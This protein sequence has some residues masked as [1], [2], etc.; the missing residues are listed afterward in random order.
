MDS[1][2]SSNFHVLQKLTDSTDWA[3]ESL[4]NLLREC[5]TIVETD[6]DQWS[7]E[8]EEAGPPPGII[9][10]ICPNNCQGNGNCIEGLCQCFHPWI[11][12]DCS[13]N[14]TVPPELHKVGDGEPCDSVCSECLS[15]RLYGENFADV[16]NVTCH[17]RILNLRL[18]PISDAKT[19]KAAYLNSEIIKCTFPDVAL[20]EI[21]VS[22]DGEIT[23]EYK[24]YIVFNSH[25][26]Q[27]NSSWCTIRLK[28]FQ[29]GVT[30]FKIFLVT[31]FIRRIPEF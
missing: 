31:L 22:N 27:C 6:T 11:G 2:S 18:D 3:K 14:S 7:N 1:F 23:S 28:T 25:C 24:Q 8:T 20:Y 15:V 16:E 9:N 12:D 13:V 30:I 21:A 10:L 17:Y 19:I 29:R 4:A 5:I 26:H